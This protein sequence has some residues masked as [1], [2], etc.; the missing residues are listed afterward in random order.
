MMFN[1]LA[2]CKR[3]QNNVLYSHCLYS[4][5]DSAYALC[6]IHSYSNKTLRVRN[7]LIHQTGLTSGSVRVRRPLSVTK[8]AAWALGRNLDDL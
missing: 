3:V 2:V 8:A 6:S 5:E 7:Q 1:L 4:G